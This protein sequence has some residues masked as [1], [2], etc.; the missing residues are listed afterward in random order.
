MLSWLVM[1][2]APNVPVAGARVH[3]GVVLW[4]SLM[5]RLP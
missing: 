3:C 4:G 5:L 2:S 1:H